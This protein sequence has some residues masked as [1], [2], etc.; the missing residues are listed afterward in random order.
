[1]KVTELTVGGECAKAGM[2]AGSALISV[3]GKAKRWR[4]A[5]EVFDGM[6][7]AGVQPNEFHFSGA[8]S[9]CVRSG[10]AD[11]ALR[12][13]DSMGPKGVRPNAVV[14]NSA[15]SA[16]GGGGRSDRALSLL[17]ENPDNRV[18]GSLL[19]SLAHHSSRC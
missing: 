3:C 18:R 1:M 12:L 7:S 13:F 6:A 19:I 11:V 9:A 15:I 10:Q 8:I 16:C 14:Y 17:A 2:F 4:Q 5:V